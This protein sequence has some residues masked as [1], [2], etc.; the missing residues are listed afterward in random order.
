MNTIDVSYLSGNFD[1][2]NYDKEVSYKIGLMATNWFG[3][4]IQILI[5]GICSGYQLKHSLRFELR[6][7]SRFV[8]ETLKSNIENFISRLA[9]KKLIV[10]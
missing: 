8:I 1:D 5:S 7:D 10:V 9:N 4:R 2:I 6:S 3:D